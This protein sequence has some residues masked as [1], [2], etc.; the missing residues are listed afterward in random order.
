MSA[1]VTI[2]VPHRLGR[3]GARERLRSRIGELKD[4]IPGGMATVASSWPSE[5]E[6]ALEIGAMGQAVSARLEVQETLVR[7]HLVLPP[8]LAFFSGMIGSAVREGGTRM[9]EDKSK[10]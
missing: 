9:L 5:D 1:P 7:V 8:M 10:G 3:D 6:M 4:H 2:D